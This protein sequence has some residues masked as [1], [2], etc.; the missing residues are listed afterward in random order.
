M[1]VVIRSSIFSFFNAYRLLLVMDLTRRET[2][3]K[4]T[5]L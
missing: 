1:A 3:V 4:C 2:Q 5:H